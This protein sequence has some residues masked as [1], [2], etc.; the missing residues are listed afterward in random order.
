MWGGLGTAAGVGV[1]SSS[2]R[3]GRDSVVAGGVAGSMAAAAA[4]AEEKK[5]CVTLRIKYGL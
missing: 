1:G 3:P 4:K 2:T 5:R